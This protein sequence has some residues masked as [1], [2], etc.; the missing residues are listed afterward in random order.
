MR[1]PRW[2]RW[3]RQRQV[4]RMVFADVVRIAVAGVAMGTLVAVAALLRED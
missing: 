2:M 3:R 1:L 4:I